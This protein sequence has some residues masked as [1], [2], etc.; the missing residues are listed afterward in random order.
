VGKMA[1]RASCA[2]MDTQLFIHSRG[3]VRFFGLYFR[4]LFLHLVAGLYWQVAVKEKCGK[5]FQ[6]TV[7]LTRSSFLSPVIFDSTQID[8]KVAVQEQNKSD[9]DELIFRYQENLNS[10]QCHS[11]YP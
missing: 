8:L 2:S 6:H 3:G 10:F 7:Y 5:S 11:G 1:T 9:F 4:V